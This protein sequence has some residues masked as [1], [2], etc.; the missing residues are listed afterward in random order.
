M[1]IAELELTKEDVGE[2]LHDVMSMLQF[3]MGQWSAKTEMMAE[4]FHTC[5]QSYLRY[6]WPPEQG[7]PGC[8]IQLQKWVDRLYLKM[9]Y[10]L[11]GWDAVVEAAERNIQLKI[12]QAH[13]RRNMGAGI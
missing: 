11:F 1:T 8:K 5:S 3:R 6:P 12:D 7:C 9:P 13:A 4:H 10:L 2:S